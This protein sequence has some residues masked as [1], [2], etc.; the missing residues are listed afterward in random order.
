MIIDSFK[1]IENGQVVDNLFHE[2]MICD[3]LEL[4]HF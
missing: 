3:L 2:K 4:H 1:K